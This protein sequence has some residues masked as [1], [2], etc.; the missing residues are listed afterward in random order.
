MTIFI[1]FSCLFLFSYILFT[2]IYC[3]IIRI[4]IKGFYIYIFCKVS[5]QFM[6]IVQSCKLHAWFFLIIWKKTFIVSKGSNSG[7]YSYDDDVWNKFFG[8]YKSMHN[9]IF[10]LIVHVHNIIK[11]KLLRPIVFAFFIVFCFKISSPGHVVNDEK[12]FS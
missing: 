12:Y 1:L 10:L 11:E 4:K 7:S 2:I 3:I 8:K 6:K 9:K 5:W